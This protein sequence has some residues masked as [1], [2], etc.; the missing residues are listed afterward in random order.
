MTAQRY[1]PHVAHTRWSPNRSTRGGAHP[2]LIVIHAT[3]GHNRRGISDLIGLGEWF[4]VGSVQAGNPVSCTV[5]TD[6][7]GHSARYV[8]DVDKAWHCAAY[9]RPA[10]GIEQVAPGDGTEITRDMYRET[11]RWVAL[12]SREHHIP[13]QHARV[14]N[15]MILRPGIIRHSELGQLGGGHADPGPYDMHAMHSLALFY[16]AHQ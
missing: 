16:R 13:I 3:A 5:A 10:L 9:N 12:W 14:E 15:G 1:H 4:A 7:E 6:N 11:A 8:R 2:T